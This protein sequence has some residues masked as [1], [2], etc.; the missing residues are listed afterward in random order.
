MTELLQVS[1][2]GTG[3]LEVGVGMQAAAGAVG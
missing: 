1:R 3:G 2:A